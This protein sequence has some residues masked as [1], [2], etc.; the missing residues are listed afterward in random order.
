MTILANMDPEATVIFVI[1]G[2]VLVLFV[3]AGVRDILKRR[4]DEDSI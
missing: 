2:I 1:T 3:I 4:D